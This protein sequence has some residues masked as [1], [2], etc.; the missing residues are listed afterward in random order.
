MCAAA[1]GRAVLVAG[2][3]GEG[4]E[5]PWCSRPGALADPTPSWFSLRA[6]PSAST[7]SPICANREACACSGAAL[8]APRLPTPGSPI[9]VYL[10]DSIGELARPTAAPPSLSSEPASSRR[11]GRTSRARAVGI[12]AIAGPH[13]DHC[14][15]RG[16][17]ASGAGYRVRDGAELP[18]RLVEALEHPARDDQ[19]SRSGDAVRGAEPRSS[20]RPRAACSP[21]PGPGGRSAGPRP[22]TLPA[23]SRL[24]GKAGA[25]RP[26]LREG[27]W[28]RTLCRALGVGRQ[29]DPRRHGQDAVRRVPRAPLPLRRPPS[30]DPAR[31]SGRSRDGVVVVSAGEGRWSPPT[32]A[33][34]SPCPSPARSPACWSW[35]RSAGGAARRAVDLGADL[36][37]LDD[38]FQHLAVRRDVTCS[39]STHGSPFGGGHFRAPRP[40]PGS[41]S[42]R[43]KRLADASCSPASTAA[44][45][46]PRRGRRCPAPSGRARL[47][48]RIRASPSGRAGAESS[49][50]CWARAA[51]WASA[52][53]P[54]APSSRRRFASWP[55]RRR[56]SSVS[57][58]T[59][60]A[61]DRHLARIRDAAHR[62]GAA[63]ILTTERDAAKLA[64]RDRIAHC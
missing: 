6:G 28:S 60:A 55:C 52:A 22:V 15:G 61:R 1:A 45:R 5:E 38:G 37:L 27:R 40:A 7:P 21:S 18:T 57:G 47:P 4:E 10:L 19:A 11:A 8:P 3:T 20:P 59:S 49:R 33:A 23:I 14:G 25:A 48:A 17:E 50:R 2:S 53:S 34:T 9:D 62:T 32:K 63:W 56:R 41:R 35:S 44:R 58:T 29:P 36:L 26:A 16:A 13:I 46:L 64:G 42:R 30:R 43:W 54:T 12:P 24:Y 31:G 39:C 51:A